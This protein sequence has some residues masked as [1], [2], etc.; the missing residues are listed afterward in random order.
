MMVTSLFSPLPATPPPRGGALCVA[1]AVIIAVLICPPALAV[2]RPDIPQ[3]NPLAAPLCLTLDQAVHMA[4]R[5]NR[6]LA[7]AENSVTSAELS[8]K[9]DLSAFDLKYS[10]TASFGATDENRA[11]AAGISFSKRFAYGPDLTVT[12][13]L[14]RSEDANSG[15]VNLSIGVPLLRGLGKRVNLDAVDASVFA[16]VSTER[17]LYLSRVD[18]VVQ[19]ISAVY[20]IMGQQRIIE[21]INS[22]AEALQRNVETARIKK[23][24][25]LATA[26]DVYRATIRL[27]DAQDRLSTARNSLHARQDDLKR[28]L[29]LPLERRIAVAA[30]MDCA[31]PKVDPDDAMQTALKN[32]VEMKQAMEA[33]REAERESLVAKH[34]LLPQLDLRFDYQ[35][36]SDT[37]DIGG[38]LDFNKE[39]WLVNLVSTTD[40]A[41]TREKAD[42]RKSLLNIENAKLALCS[43]K[44]AVI[45]EVRN[46]LE[47]LENWKARMRIRQEQIREATGKLKLS[48]IKFQHGLADNFDLIEAETE[49]FEARESLI[50]VETEYMVSRYLLRAAMGTLLMETGEVH[51]EL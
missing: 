5:A 1:L 35:R 20:G 19:T 14:S 9:S 50:T 26:L 44:E 36:Y 16:R 38:S 24:A 27:K 43:Q 34:N 21:L 28:I 29:S 48:R 25:Q 37:E 18:T 7:V 2:E 45:S 3:E 31:G 12:P 47:I 6:S 17:R 51:L 13:L 39:R 49:L 46:Q 11:A 23:E 33:V 15:A 4:L 40:W 10:P 8:L 30:E 41:R 42:Y 32:R 22:H